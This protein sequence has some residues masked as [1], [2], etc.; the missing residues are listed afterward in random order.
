MNCNCIEKI[1]KKLIEQTKDKDAHIITTFGIRDNT[2]ITV[3]TIP[4][5]YQEFKKDGTRK[6]YKTKGTIVVSHCPFCG[7]SKE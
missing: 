4:V 1:N 2:M 3:I 7:N 6:R 5:E